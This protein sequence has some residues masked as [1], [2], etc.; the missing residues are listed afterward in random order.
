MKLH[1][2]AVSNYYNI[3]KLA[4]LEKHLRF[5]EV[6]VPPSDDPEFLLHSPMGKIPFLQHGDFFLSESQ[7]ILFYLELYK[8]G[9]RLFPLDPAVSGLTQQVHQFIDLYIDPPAR[10]LLGAAYFGRSASEQ[11]VADASQQLKQRIG[12]LSQIVRFAPFISAPSLTHADL[13]AF[14]TLRFAQAV[15]ER[16]N[17]PD[18]LTRLP[19]VG[20]WM[21]MMAERPASQR[22]IEDQ[23]QALQQLQAH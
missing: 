17:G 6:R 11:Q 15:M 22:V 18:P 7:A 19:G 16:V 3:V 2:L 9:P 4:L 13:A 20:A 21:D 23:E 12:A 14:M 1:G 5:E 8:P 10:S